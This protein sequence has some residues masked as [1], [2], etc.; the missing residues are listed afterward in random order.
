METTPPIYSRPEAAIQLAHAELSRNAIEN[1][2]RI[3]LSIM[4]TVRGDAA[5]SC[6]EL[7]IRARR[8]D[9]ATSLAERIAT[10]MH[11][12]KHAAGSTWPGAVMHHR[13]HHQAV[14]QGEAA[15]CDRLEQQR[16]CGIGGG[17]GRC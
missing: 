4:P 6:A 13:R 1:G 11:I 12:V 8:I 5:R 14:L 9:E 7:L 3:L 16:A 15:D 10:E 17:G 2:A